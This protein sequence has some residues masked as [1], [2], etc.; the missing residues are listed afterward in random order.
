M[1]K[2]VVWANGFAAYD[3]IE[4]AEEMRHMKMKFAFLHQ[5]VTI[6]KKQLQ[7]THWGWRFACACIFRNG[8]RAFYGITDA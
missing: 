1:S 3:E 2:T 5:V 6:H 8:P 7:I 4:T